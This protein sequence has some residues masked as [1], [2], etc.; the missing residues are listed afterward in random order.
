[1]SI[2][3]LDPGN[4]TSDLQSGAVTHYKVGNWTLAT[5]PLS[6]SLGPSLTSGLLPGPQ[7]HYLLAV[8][9]SCSLQGCL[10]LATSPQ[11]YRLELFT[12]PPK[13]S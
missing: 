5:L 3:Y 13:K 12:N 9:G 11:M 8:N 7:P 10:Y 4:I 2:A 6:C 1:M